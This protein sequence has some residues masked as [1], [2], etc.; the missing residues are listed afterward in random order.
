MR[1]AM[2]SMVSPAEAGRTLAQRT[3]ALRL[4]KG[5]KRDTL[6]GRAG[7]SVSS[8]KRF[9][10][11]GRGSLDLVLKVAL[12]LGRLAEFGKLLEPPPAESMA[13]LERLAARP[14]RKRGRI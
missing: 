2:L 4:M 14:V 12:A 6:A 11:T 3:K 13:E 9:E 8:L 10:T 1:R 7:V 5:W